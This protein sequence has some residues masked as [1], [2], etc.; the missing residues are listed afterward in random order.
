MIHVRE[1]KLITLIH[2]QEKAIII[3][4]L[5]RTLEEEWSR[6]TTHIPWGLEKR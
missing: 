6:G 5:T 3:D 4:V 2:V 1:K